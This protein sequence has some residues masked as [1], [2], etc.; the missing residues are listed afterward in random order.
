MSVTNGTVPQS[1][2]GTAYQ[3]YRGT[4][5]WSTFEGDG[6]KFD[7]TE[8]FLWVDAEGHVSSVSEEE[9]KNLSASLR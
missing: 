1:L 6:Y 2:I 5:I 9:G 7:L 8:E 4:I 3:G